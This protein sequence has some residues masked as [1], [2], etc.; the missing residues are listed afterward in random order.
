MDVSEHGPQACVFAPTPL[1]TV[2][3][4]SRADG[5]PDVHVHSG[6]QGVWVANMLSVLDTRTLLCGPFGGETG[7][8]L[9]SLLGQGPLVLRTVRAAG[10][11]GS[12][13][14][15]R[16]SGDLTCVAEMPAGVLD[17]HEKDDLYN[18]VLQSAVE[19]AVTVLTGPAHPHVVTPDFYRR[20]TTDV[21]ALGVPVVADLSGGL[22]SA[23][24]DGG[25]SVLKVSHEELIAD[26]RA[27]TDDVEDLARAAEELSRRVSRMVVVTRAGEPALAHVAGEVLEVRAP[28]LQTV[29]ARGAGDS[30]TAGIATTLAQGADLESALRLG[31]AAGMVNVTRHGLATGQRDAIHRIAD[32]VEIEPW[33]AGTT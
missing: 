14:E 12:F 27:G 2:T 30:M 10:S 4:E 17:R 22:L 13:V 28:M 18:A 26:G 25:V 1:L 24:L 6:G 29:H 19:S 32:R 33:K 11:N 3:I 8:V 21:A 9:E 16:R 7:R 15:D 5:T 31:A 23:A 20:L